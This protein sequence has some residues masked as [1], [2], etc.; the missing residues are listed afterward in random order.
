MK[1]AKSRNNGFFPCVKEGSFFSASQFW[2]RNSGLINITTPRIGGLITMMLSQQNKQ[3]YLLTKPVGLPLPNATENRKSVLKSSEPTASMVSWE[4]EK[5]EM[6]LL[7]DAMRSVCY[8]YSADCRNIEKLH[9]TGAGT[10]TAK[11][12]NDPPCKYPTI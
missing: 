2:L 3:K 11:L 9:D 12:V 5:K 10:E 1:Q 6:T 4:E 8:I 7:G